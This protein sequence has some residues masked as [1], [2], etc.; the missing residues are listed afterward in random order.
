[1]TTLGDIIDRYPVTLDLLRCVGIRYWY[2]RGT[3]RTPWERMRDGVDCSAYVAMSL[4]HAGVYSSSQP[5]RRAT[6][7]T[8]TLKSIADI[9][10][11]TKAPQFADVAIYPGHVMFVLDEDL[12]IGASGGDST[13]YGD[14]PKACVQL[15]RPDYRKDFLCFG[16][17]R[18]EHRLSP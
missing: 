11:E 14:N 16:Q 1:M 18:P 13:T 15:H 12:V 17:L 4:V 10:V 8:P 7:S 5:D 6:A 2:G 9:C 3:P